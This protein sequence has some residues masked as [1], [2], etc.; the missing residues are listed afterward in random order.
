MTRHAMVMM[1]V[2]GVG[3]D[4][5]AET[6]EPETTDPVT[7]TPEVA[8]APPEA[9]TAGA[10]DESAEARVATESYV[11]ELRP[12]ESYTTGELGQLAI[13]LSGQGEWH[14]NQDFPFSVEVSHDAEVTV[15]KARLGKD[16]AAEFADEAARVD[17][18]LTPTAAGEHP[19][20]AVVS[21]A[22]CNPES[23]V[24]HT[25]TVGVRL[26]VQ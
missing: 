3:C 4:E 6:P 11:V 26:A 8:E 19:V 24:P 14:L 16:D 21:F 25:E 12:A 18:P 10:P 13:H 20:S 2:L 9:E 15:P 5:P 7:E 23:C 22:V 17:I 1:L